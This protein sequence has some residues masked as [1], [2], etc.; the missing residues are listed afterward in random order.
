MPLQ[1]QGNEALKR[2]KTWVFGVIAAVAV[3]AVIAGVGL[4]KYHE[5]PQFCAT[6]HIMQPYLDSWKNPGLLAHGH[7]EAGVTCLECHEPTLKQQVEELVKYVT[8]DYQTP[9]KQR[10]FSMDWCFRC[11]EHGTYAELA[12]RT[13]DR[14]RNPHDSHYGQLECRLCHRVHQTSELYCAT[15]H[16]D[17]PLPENWTRPTQP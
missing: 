3:L 14:E 1:N 10:K 7:A 12:E 5:Q 6:C 16:D 17:V 4:W 8:A 9:L 13:A 11:H 2:R 15:C